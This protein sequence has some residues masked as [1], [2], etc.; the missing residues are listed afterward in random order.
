MSDKKRDNQIHTG[1]T[2]LINIKDLIRGA[3]TVDYALEDILSE[4]GGDE[5]GTIVPFPG[6]AAEPAPEEAP[7][8]PIPEEENR[9]ERT[10]IKSW[11]FRRRRACCPPWSRP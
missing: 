6:P 7:E 2:E 11:T 10:R 9:R 8:E 3:E 4:F 5:R 1:N